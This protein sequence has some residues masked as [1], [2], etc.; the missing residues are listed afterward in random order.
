MLTLTHTCCPSALNYVPITI[1]NT[2]DIVHS[3]EDRLWRQQKGKWRDKV[4]WQH[5]YEQV[6]CEEK[7]RRGKGN[8]RNRLYCKDTEVLLRLLNRGMLAFSNY[9]RETG[10]GEAQGVYSV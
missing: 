5:G 8:G 10:R 7:G 9:R 4:Y 3:W 1:K 6:S 2:V